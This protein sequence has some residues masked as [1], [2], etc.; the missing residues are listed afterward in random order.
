MDLT[1][2]WTRFKSKSIFSITCVKTQCAQKEL[3]SLLMAIHQVLAVIPDLKQAAANLTR[4]RQKTIDPRVD[5]L[6]SY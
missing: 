5:P 3:S 1:L 6:R 4:I 2:N